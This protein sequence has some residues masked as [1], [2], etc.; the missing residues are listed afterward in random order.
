MQW[1]DMFVWFFDKQESEFL[2]YLDAQK[3]QWEVI[4]II[5]VM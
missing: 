3:V 4:F 5:S 1:I 2:D